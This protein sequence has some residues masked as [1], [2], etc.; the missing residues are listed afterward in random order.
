MKR[1]ITAT[2]LMLALIGPSFAQNAPVA[3]KRARP[4]QSSE[5]RLVGTVKG[6]KLWAGNCVSAEPTAPRAAEPGPPSQDREK[7]ALP[8]Q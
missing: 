6:T 7:E 2:Y 4:Q 3:G 1:S 5:C 8:K